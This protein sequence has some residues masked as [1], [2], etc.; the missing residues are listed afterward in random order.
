MNFS[1]WN[2]TPPSPT[3]FQFL[4]SAFAFDDKGNPKPDTNNLFVWSRPDTDALSLTV[5]DALTEEEL[6]EASKKLQHIIHDEAIFLPSFTT[7]FQR[8]GSWRWV[9]WPDSAETRYAPAL[10]YEPHE[11]YCYWIDEDVRKETQ[12]ARRSGKTFPEVNRVV[13]PPETDQP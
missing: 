9:R 11:G 2:T 10:S 8:V 7:E 4:H 1:G 5:R 13:H 3:Y 6:A 12:E